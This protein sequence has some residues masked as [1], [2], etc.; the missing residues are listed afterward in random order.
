MFAKS[1][2]SRVSKV[3]LLSRVYV[4][5]ANEG[6]LGNLKEG[7]ACEEDENEEGEE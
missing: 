5:S 4:C 7:E 3:I 6:V 2:F 1:L